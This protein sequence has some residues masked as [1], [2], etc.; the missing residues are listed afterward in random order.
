MTGVTVND[1]GDDSGIARDNSGLLFE[2]D[3]N[4][5]TFTTFD[6]PT[7]A[8]GTG[9]GTLTLTGLLVGEDFTH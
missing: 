2:F 4:L 8:D 5:A 3:G 7:A 6:V 9:M 1:G